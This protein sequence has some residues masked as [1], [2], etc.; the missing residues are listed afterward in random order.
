MN[1]IYATESLESLNSKSIFL[2]GPTPRSKEVETWRN[3]AIEI[4]TSLGFDGD[5]L[6]PEPRNG[7]FTHSYDS[8]IDWELEGLTKSGVIVFWIPR[9]LNLMPALTTNVE[10][11]AWYKSG[12]IVL[13]SPLTAVK[14]NYLI[15]VAEL[16][17]IKHH[18]TLKSTLEEALSK[19]EPT[20][21]GY[22]KTW[23]T[24]DTHF[25]CERALKLSRRPFKNVS[26]MDET[27]ISNWN[28]VVKPGDT[29]YHL[30]D[31]GD[32]HIAKR[33]NGNITL[34]FGN[35]ERREFAS[36]LVG[37]DSLVSEFG[38]AAVFEDPIDFTSELVS[39]RL[40]HEPSARIQ[41]M[42]HLFGHIHECQMIKKNSLNVGVDCHHFTPIEL[43]TVLYYKESIESHYDSD[44]FVN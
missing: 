42:F 10:F 15:Y 44:V 2:A 26:H 29:V 7:Q 34:L 13:G 39:V 32:Y 43:K 8:Q 6:I 37:K 30:G 1:L 25:G 16:E 27:M 24:S 18:D 14:M 17:D 21:S 20:L 4:L 23:F 22:A 38:F 33:L 12:K 5:V 35:Y 40:V 36:G 28:R 41:G 3:D 11:G 19:F 9:E 31:F